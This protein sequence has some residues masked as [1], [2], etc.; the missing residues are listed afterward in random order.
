MMSIDRI[1]KALGGDVSGGQV[2]APGPGHSAEDRSL[3]VKL[4]DT[5]P[6]GFVV[7]SFAGD[8]AI[9]CRD[10]VRR[11]IGA[12]EFESKAKKKKVNGGARAYS[13]TIAKYVYR[14]ADGTPYLQVHRLAD[15]S[16]FPQYHWDGEKW[17][18]GKPKGPKIPYM[19][20]ELTAAAPTTPI[21]V[22]EGEKDC[23]N[24]AKLG[25]VAT[26]NSEGA[27]NG[28]GNKWT[29]DLNHYFKDRDVYII[30]DNDAQG[31]KHAQHVARNLDP[32]AKSVR[33]VEL[34]GLPLKGD[35][36][37]WLKSDTAGAKLAKLAAAAPLWEASAEKAGGSTA[38]DELL[39]LEL[40]GLSKLQYAKRR[41]DAAETI[42]IGVG[43]LDKIVAETRGDDKDEPAPALYEHWNV[44]GANAPVDS[45]I[46]LRA[47]KEAIQRYV[48]MSEDQAVAVTLWIVF[49]WLHEH[50]AHSPILYVTS[51]EKDS[52]KT[53]LLGVINF[54]AR[55]AMQIVDTSG[56]ALFR[57]ITKWQPTL[58]VDEADDALA[59]NPDLRSV[60][61]SGW[62]R[63]QGVP[64]CHPDTHEPEI[65]ST[66]APKVV[67]MKGRNLPDTTLSRSIIITMKP[68]RANDPKE[69][70]E[71]FNHLDNQTFGRLRSQ[72]MRWA[73]DNADALV[74]ATPEIP[75]GFHNRRR[76]NWVP[77]LAIAEAGA[78]EWKTAAWKAA[79]AIE[80]VADT[81][82]PSIGVELL[83]A[84]KGAFEA[85]AKQASNKDRITST[86]LITDLV[87][88]ETAPWATY[89]RGK[90]ISQRQV[91]GLLKPY[92][93]KPRVIRF[94][95]GTADGSTPRGYLLEWFTDAFDRFCTS[96][97]AHPPFSSATSATDLFSK[98]FSPFSSA[99]SPSDV[100][101][102]ND[103]KPS[104]IN[105]VA[106][107]A[108]KNGGEAEKK[109]SE[110][111]RTARLK[112][113]DLP[114]AG[115]PAAV[116]DQGPDPLD[117]HGA[118]RAA[119]AT[120]QP[121]TQGRA[122]DLA[123][124]YHDKAVIKHETS[125]TGDVDS[126]ELGAWLRVR[127]G[128]EVP[129]ELLEAAFKQV[130]DLVFAM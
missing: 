105:D 13:P 61:N 95:D 43:E 82:D 125:P 40:A 97:S 75:S 106:D 32:V 16:G 28:N 52:G 94:D 65:F 103:E 70:A 11:K 124:Q 54:L 90:P 83:R 15:K 45:G 59:D 14:L 113:D 115:P 69:H 77:L 31:H 37:D 112:S 49:S 53:T 38:S 39:I 2:R 66:F 73:A 100:A 21:Y 58:I 102:K 128:A 129:P 62:T 122:R 67:A 47:V 4:D 7:H 89:N 33:I 108:H 44:E 9:V 30:P 76:A 23:D 81:L 12:P 6:D 20:P 118:P 86:T 1:A 104:D 101:D 84:I 5:A 98:D 55:R 78:A 87:A 109:G 88:D 80:A 99:T 42:G 130:M 114:Y 107:V 26:C 92:G 123:E 34:P 46:L 17:I 68:R 18:S 51:A 24:L 74:K 93:I 91:A 8:D 64:R 72:L 117:E 29:S 119:R 22:V 71:D 96:S 50:M 85:R 19:L 116:P 127:L 48:F 63:G 126:D 111:A 36:S 110:R 60:I 41:K 10:Y 120:R 79:R 35:V 57:S 25:F 3:S 121:L 56:P 27:D